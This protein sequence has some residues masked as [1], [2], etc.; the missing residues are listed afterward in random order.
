[1]LVGLAVFLSACS[2]MKLVPVANEE[3]VPLDAEDVVLLLSAAGFSEQE[4]LDKGRELRNK[5]ARH[6]AVNLRSEGRTVVMFA[7]R[8]GLVHVVTTTVGSFVY[9]PATD[10]V[11]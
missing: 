10:T 3:K 5:L 11:R 8:S 9:D 6:G 1:M 7:V 2:G 4:I